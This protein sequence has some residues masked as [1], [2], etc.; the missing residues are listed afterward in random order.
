MQRHRDLHF[1]GR[2]GAPISVLLTTLAARAYAH[3]V[4]TNT[5][6]SEFDLLLDVLEYM[7]VFIDCVEIAGGV[8]YSVPN[9]TTQGE[10]FAEKWNTDPTLAQAFYSWLKQAEADLRRLEEQS[11][12]DALQQ[13]LG[14][15]V[16]T[17]EARRVLAKQAATVNRARQEGSLFLDRNLGVSSVGALAVPR[18]TFYGR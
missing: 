14:R 10:N 18:N 8:R 12:T 5:Y 3:V 6:D 2:P 9:P 15:T 7:P 11:G 1:T 16:G 17:D 13:F 4:V